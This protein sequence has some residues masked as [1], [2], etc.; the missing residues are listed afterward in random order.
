MRLKPDTMDLT[1]ELFRQIVESPETEASS[2][3]GAEVSRVEQRRTPRTRLDV[4]A[5]LL[6]FSDRVGLKPVSVLVR[7]LSRGGLRFLHDQPLPL[8]EAFGLLLP[9]ASGRPIVILC[10][11]TYW[12]PLSPELFAIGARFCQVLRQTDPPLP[13]ELHDVVSGEQLDFRKAS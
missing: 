3:A 6:P 4:E 7:D 11:V 1:S 10:T 5:T 13:L 8:G 2:R 9:D 12:Q